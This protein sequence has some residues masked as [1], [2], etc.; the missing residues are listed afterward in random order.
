MVDMND[1]SYGPILKQIM[2]LDAL[3][4]QRRVCKTRQHLIQRYMNTTND[5]VR[6]SARVRVRVRI[7]VKGLGLGFRVRV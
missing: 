2:N 5:R 6:V 4:T 3:Q 1:F 7:R